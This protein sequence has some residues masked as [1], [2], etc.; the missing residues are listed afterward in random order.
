MKIRIIV[1]EFSK[2]VT[3]ISFSSWSLG[4][5]FLGR[6]LKNP[7]MSIRVRKGTYGTVATVDLSR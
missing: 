3:V 4:M 2:R 7:A 6:Q 5:S 1:H